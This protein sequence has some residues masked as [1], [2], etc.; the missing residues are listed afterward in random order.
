MDVFLISNMYPDS[1]SPGF[2][3]FV[4]NVVDGLEKKGIHV[5]CSSLI[6][7]QRKSKLGKIIK[8][9]RF[10]FSICLNFFRT[11]DL[12]YI[13]FP[14]H[15]LPILLPLLFFRKR[16]VIVN[17][18]GEDLLYNGFIGSILGGLNDSF[19]AHVDR[20]I[21]PSNYFENEVLN[22]HLS[23][24]DKIF[25]SPSGGIDNNIFFPINKQYN[26]DR[27]CVGY[28]GRIEDGKGVQEFVEALFEINKYFSCEA[29]IIGYGSF[30]NELF[31]MIET[32]SLSDKVQVIK[33]VNQKDLCEYY[34]LFDL[35]LFLSKR[36]AESLGLVGIEAMAC[37]V[38]VVGTDNGGIPSYLLNEYNGFLVPKNDVQAVVEAVVKYH[39]VNDQER[40][41]MQ[42]NAIETSKKYFRDKVCEDLSK[43]FYTLK[44]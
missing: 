14:N 22:R 30:E 25:V 24:E 20:I 27:F 11:Y 18:H 38:P 15:A 26:R 39:S 3:V 10:Y 35:F 43:A 9:L 19:L 5:K 31:E 6:K 2:G 4:K 1:S 41:V 34:N 42:K 13:H 36:D 32:F 8:Y 17:L 40:R 21:V 33:G 44:V 23:S 12:I 16:T 37:G 28:V 7:G 29:I